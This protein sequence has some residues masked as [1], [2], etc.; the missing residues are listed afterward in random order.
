VGAI[1]RDLSRI[2]IGI[3][4]ELLRYND[5]VGS[6]GKKGI[7][8]LAKPGVITNTNIIAVRDGINT[9]TRVIGLDIGKYLKFNPWG[10]TKLASGIGS[11]LAV[12]GVALEIWDSYKEQERKAKFTVA[13]NTMIDNF[14]NQAK[15]II[16]LIDAPNFSEQFFPDFADLR[17]QLT[18][19]GNEMS[20]LQERQLRFKRWHENGIAIDAEFREIDQSQ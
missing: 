19:I 16:T 13:I 1:S 18:G 14:K 15:E 2:E 5:V 4:N 6:L 3:Q 17:R 9:A 12:V 11:A 20:T 7:Q 10:A 8:F